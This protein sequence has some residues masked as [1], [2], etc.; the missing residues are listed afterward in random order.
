MLNGLVDLRR[1]S[2][3]RRCLMPLRRLKAHEKMLPLDGILVEEV[4]AAGPRRQLDG[5][6]SRGAVGANDIRRKWQ[7]K[8]P[9]K[10]AD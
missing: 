5:R 3:E 6:R 4:H 1:G 2:A 8:E 9:D 10:S 7:L